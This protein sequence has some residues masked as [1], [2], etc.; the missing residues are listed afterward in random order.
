MLGLSDRG[1]IRRLLGLLLAGDAQGALAALKG[2]YELGVEPSAVLRGLLESVHGI[3]RAKVGGADDS[4]LSAEERDAYAEWSG[5]L[6]YA[7]IH[8]LW[9]L[10]LKGLGEVNSAPMPLEAAEMAL[11]RVI[12]ASEMPDPGALLERLA[13]GEA[14]T[15]PARA[16]APAAPAAAA[17]QAIEAPARPS[18]PSPP[19]VAAQAPA[20][21][22]QAAAAD[23]PPPWEEAPAGPGDAEA[24]AAAAAAGPSAPASFRDL[25]EALALNGKPHLAQQL[26]DFCG[27]VRYAPPVLAIRPVKPMSGDLIRDLGAAL[28]K[29]TGETWQVSAEDGVAEP[30]L[31]EQDKMAAAQERQDVLDSPLIKAAFEAF[32]GAELSGYTLDEQRSA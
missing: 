2:Q 27:V 26:H 25:V 1:A 11:L 29:L 28:H 3:T 17:P 8:R 20:P 14:V 13:S 24:P 22:A 31:L 21:A 32:P 12:H 6:S 19:P 9:Q 4:A 30:T 7:A 18:D 15:L 23:E 10:L 5:R 16:A